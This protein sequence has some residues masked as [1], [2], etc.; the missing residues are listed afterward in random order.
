MAGDESTLRR[1]LVP[2]FV[3]RTVL[4]GATYSTGREIVEFFLRYGP[5][6]SLIG[7][8]IT[9]AVYSLFCMLAFE[10]ARRYKVLDYR[11]FCRIYMGRWWWLYE[12]GFI[13]GVILTLATIAAA[14]GEFGS[15][16]FGLSKLNG[17]LILMAAIAAL[18]YFGTERLE[19]LMSIWSIIFYSL[20]GV[21][22]VGSLYAFGAVLSRK[23]VIEPI[24]FDGI[25]AALLYALFNCAILPVV[26]FVA[27]HFR[28]RK[29]AVMAG[30]LAGP[31]LMLPG[32]AILLMLIPLHPGVIDEPLPITM[33][34]KSLGLPWATAVIEIAIVI[35]L[36]FNGSA[37]L[38]GFNERIA[39]AMAE[40]KT[41][42][43][44]SG[45]L[46]S[47][48][49]LISLIF[50]AFVADWIGLID[51]VGEGMRYGAYV[52]LVVMLVPLLTRGFWM[53]RRT[54]AAE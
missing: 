52:F 22:L 3:I 26:I 37:L 41:R 27:R 51:L 7:L 25:F 12:I 29:D 14:A 48:I 35:E 30:A 34:L 2:G 16:T 23:L 49:A 6:P 33:V 31:L 36:A 9:T 19:K 13:F 8:V 50:S 43:Q 17:A 18:V 47:V 11:S 38:H 5:V 1:Y 20:Y 40:K 46:R 45:G 15:D 10:L 24:T 42:I 32:L 21:L 4:I 28:S 53:T 44:M 54:Q 39:T